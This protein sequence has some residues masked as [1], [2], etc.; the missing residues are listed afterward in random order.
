MMLNKKVNDSSA[1]NSQWVVFWFCSFGHG[2]LRWCGVADSSDINWIY[3]DCCHDIISLSSTQDSTIESW[4]TISQHIKTKS[5]IIISNEKSAPAW[6]SLL[7]VTLISTTDHVSSNTTCNK[8]QQWCGMW[9]DI[10]IWRTGSCL[11]SKF[12]SMCKRIFS[13]PC[14]LWTTCNKLMAP[15]AESPLWWRDKLQSS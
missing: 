6:S 9:V 12:I 3:Y 7:Q 14:E 8:Q 13:W 10:R 2:R 5:R 15:G 4:S 11:Q 1:T